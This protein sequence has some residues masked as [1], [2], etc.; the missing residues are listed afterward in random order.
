MSCEEWNNLRQPR[1]DQRNTWTACFAMRVANRR[2]GEKDI[3]WINYWGIIINESIGALFLWVMY[4]GINLGGSAGLHN[5][6]AGML[7]S[8]ADNLQNLASYNM[9]SLKQT[10]ILQRPNLTAMRLRELLR[11]KER[12]KSL[13][14]R[15]YEGHRVHNGWDN[16]IPKSYT[17]G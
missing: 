1:L 4:V 11:K 12:K 14:R 16:P 8:T 7:S 10:Y 5:D 3:D 15:A 13:P 2:T 17:W 6:S 9:F